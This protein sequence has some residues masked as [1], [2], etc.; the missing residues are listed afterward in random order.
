MSKLY[1]CV[2][3]LTLVIGLLILG[4]TVFAQD[5]RVTLDSLEQ[6]LQITTESD[7]RL[8]ILSDGLKH[9]IFND[10]DI[11]YGYVLRFEKEAQKSGVSEEIARSKNFFGMPASMTGDHYRAI[12]AYRQSYL[13]YVELGDSL[14]IGIMLN[15]LGSAYEYRAERD[16]SLAY[17]SKASDVF[18]RIGEEEWVN[19]AK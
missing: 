2:N 15:N 5:F 7:A 17:F 10:L 6:Q 3:R 12:E 1:H 8:K 16:S 9:S 14:M 4:T 18:E 13:S 19:S 11:A